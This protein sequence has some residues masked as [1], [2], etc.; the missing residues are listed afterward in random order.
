MFGEQRRRDAKGFFFGLIGVSDETPLHHIGRAGNFREQTGDQSAGAAFGSDDADVFGARRIQ[1]S[2]R[3]TQKRGREHQITRKYCTM[4]PMMAAARPAST[5]SAITPMPPGSF[6]AAEI[7]QGFRTSNS[8]NRRKASANSGAE[9]GPK[10]REIPAQASHWPASSS[11][12]HS[13]G[14]S[15]PVART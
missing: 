9:P 5:S 11:I 12:T 2:P 10:P 8:R 6:S 7:G 3:L 4:P 1:Q 14:S 15:R 13:E